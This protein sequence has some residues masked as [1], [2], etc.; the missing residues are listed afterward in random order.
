MFHTVTTDG[1]VQSDH[2]L[3]LTVPADLPP[4]PVT[5]TITSEAHVPDRISTLGD[6][7]ESGFVGMWADRKDLP[8]T[9][10]EFSVWRRKLWERN[11]D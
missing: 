7:L 2:T 11:Q 1:E 5:V 6:L 10:N 4:G 8:R 9:D 3:V